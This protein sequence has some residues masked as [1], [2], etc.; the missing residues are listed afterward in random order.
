M[1]PLVVAAT[2]CRRDEGL[3]SLGERAVRED[4]VVVAHELLPQ[5]LVPLAHVRKLVEIV[6]MIVGVHIS[7]LFHR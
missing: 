3:L 7:P 5:L 1:K 4:G 2:T 6:R